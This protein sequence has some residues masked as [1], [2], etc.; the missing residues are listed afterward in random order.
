MRKTL[1]YALLLIVFALS[2]CGESQK[3]SRD[4]ILSEKQMVSLLI[5]TH[6]VDAILISQDASASDKQDKGLFYYPS[7]LEKHGITK[8]Q[9]DSSV[10]WY[11]RN[12]EAYAR[13]YASVI[14]DLEVRK[15]AVK[16]DLPDE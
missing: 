12:P 9:M 1:I 10:A 6:L 2:S 13:I 11:M 16:L 15:A 5:E 3:K 14:K 7:V 4:G 8:A